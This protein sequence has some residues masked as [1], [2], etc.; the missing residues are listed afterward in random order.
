LIV[1]D[2]AP[3]LLHSGEFT[4]MDLKRQPALSGLFP[5]VGDWILHDVT[6]LAIN[7]SVRAFESTLLGVTVELLQKRTPTAKGEIISP[8]PTGLHCFQNHVERIDVYTVTLNNTDAGWQQLVAGGSL[9][10]TEFALKLV[11]QW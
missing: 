2:I 6:V 1:C 7:A 9:R 11:K 3:A 4:V 5:R 8:V 10:M